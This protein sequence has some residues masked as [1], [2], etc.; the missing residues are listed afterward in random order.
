MTTLIYTNTKS[1]LSRKAREKREAVLKEQREIK[2]SLQES[3][4]PLRKSILGPQPYRRETR[5]I[6]SLGT[7]VGNATLQPK[8]EYTGHQ[9]VGVAT[10]HKSNIVPVFSKEDAK[11]LARMR[12]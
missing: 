1:K 2:K 6:A 3:P 10:M 5:E 7:G 12:R 8:P 4:K 9:M 11:D